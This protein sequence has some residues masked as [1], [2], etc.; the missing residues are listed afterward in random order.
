MYRANW[1]GWNGRQLDAIEAATA[2]FKPEWQ[3]VGEF[4]A[5]HYLVLDR[6]GHAAEYFYDLPVVVLSDSGCFSAT[7]IF[8]GALELLPRVTL[9]GTASSGGSARSQSFLLP[10]TGMEVRCASMASFRPDGR[11]YDGRGIEVD[12]E[13]LPAPGDF[14]RAGGDAQLKAALKRF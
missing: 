4:S 11:L 2:V 12:V 3:P 10:K 8:L 5:W 14:L 9:L 6:T 1:D 13:V 7:D